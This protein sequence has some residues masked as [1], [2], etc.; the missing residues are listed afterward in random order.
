VNSEVYGESMSRELGDKAARVNYELRAPFEVAHARRGD[1]GG[2]WRGAEGKGGRDDCRNGCELS[3]ERR[4]T[5]PGT[6]ERAM[7]GIDRVA[8]QVAGWVA[9]A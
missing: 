4:G 9:I 3:E 8:H 2:T 7:R 1:A 6:R 5:W